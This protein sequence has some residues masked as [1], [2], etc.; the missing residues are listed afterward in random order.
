MARANGSELVYIPL[1]PKSK[2]GITLPDMLEAID[3]YWTPRANHPR[4]GANDKTLHLVEGATHIAMY[5]IYV[6]QA[7]EVLAP[8]FKRTL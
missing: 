3:Y 7:M 1:T 6:P 2:E 5:D 4:A 8:F